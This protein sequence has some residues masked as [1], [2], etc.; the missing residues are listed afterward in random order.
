MRIALVHH[1]Y[2][3]EWAGAAGPLVAEL[4]R[5]LREAGHEPAILGS[6]AGPTRRETD[7]GV[8]LIRLGRLPEWPL[9]ARGFDGPLTHVPE[10]LRELAGG[11]Y[12]VAHAFSPQ[13]AAAAAYG[14][15][16]VVFTPS[17][18]PRREALAER[19]LRLR[20]WEAAIRPP[21]VVVV[22]SEGHRQA[23]RRW[24]ALEPELAAPHDAAAHLRIYRGL[25][26]PAAPAVQT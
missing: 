5:S 23:V 7:D 15:A 1:S 22:P 21:N 18:P 26:P 6:R 4:A 13:D 16:P 8:A 24:L 17:E 3:T 19:R 10:L 12:D 9:R 14:P 20:A 11:G 2:G 25:S